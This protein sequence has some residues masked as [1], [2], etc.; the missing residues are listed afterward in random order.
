MKITTIRKDKKGKLHLKVMSF[1]TLMNS[2][3]ED[4]K[5]GD[6]DNLR[7]FVRRAESYYTFGNL[8][9][10]PYIYPSSYSALHLC[11][12]DW[13]QPT[14]SKNY[15]EHEPARWLPTRDG[16]GDGGLL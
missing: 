16:R 12:T 14:V 11:R 9:R 7:S 3:L 6:I 15:R 5:Y 4:N 13:Q 10:L 2:V 8:Y 1:G